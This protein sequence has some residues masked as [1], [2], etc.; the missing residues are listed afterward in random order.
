[1]YFAA[2][3][4]SVKV[5]LNSF[6]GENRVLIQMLFSVLGLAWTFGS[7]SWSSYIMLQP[8]PEIFLSF[9]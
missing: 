9:L 4:C 5:E 2:V 6:L 3:V 8:Q 1:M 7:Y